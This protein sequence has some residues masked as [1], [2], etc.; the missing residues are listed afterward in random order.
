M[1]MRKVQQVDT[2][3]GEKSRAQISKERERCGKRT[4]SKERKS[5]TDRIRA[6]Q[7]QR[8]M[9]KYNHEG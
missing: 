9:L 6:A 4:L 5:Q 3:T 1:P 2:Q 7:H 8:L